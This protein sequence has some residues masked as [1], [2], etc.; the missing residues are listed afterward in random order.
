MNMDIEAFL[1]SSTVVC[2]VAQRLVRKVCPHCAEKH[3]LTAD[4]LRR[5]GYRG[6]DARRLEFRRGAGCQACRHT[7]YR[8]RAPIFELLVLNEMIKDALISRKTSYEIRRISV[9]TTGLVTL[10]EDGIVK[11]SRGLTTF[12]EIIRKLPRLQS[13]RPI[14]E[15]YR[16]EGNV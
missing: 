5:L 3:V 7:G 6:Q 15:L 12:E 9:E 1:I 13:P 4:E 2:V 16:L 14:E 10:L 11:A 8:G